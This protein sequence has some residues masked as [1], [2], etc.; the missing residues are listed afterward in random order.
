MCAGRANTDSFVDGA[1]PSR[2]LIPRALPGWKG[3]DGAAPA[4]R[5]FGEITIPPTCL[6]EAPARSLKDRTRVAKGE[7]HDALL[8]EERGLVGHLRPAPLPGP[9]DLR[10]EAE[11][12]PLH[13]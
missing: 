5:P 8:D 12:L 3:R 7:G 6:A 1:R 4:K 13:R 11:H 9:K 2:P 10:V